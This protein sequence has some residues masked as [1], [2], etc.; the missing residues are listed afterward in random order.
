MKRELSKLEKEAFDN[1]KDFENAIAQQKTSIQKLEKHLKKH[2]RSEDKE[3]KA[4]LERAAKL[5][6]NVQTVIRNNVADINDPLWKRAEELGKKAKLPSNDDLLKNIGDKP[7][8]NIGMSQEAEELSPRSL[9]NSSISLAG[10]LARPISPQMA[11]VIRRLPLSLK[12]ASLVIIQK[13][14][15]KG[16]SPEETLFKLAPNGASIVELEYDLKKPHQALITSGPKLRKIVDLSKDDHIAQAVKA[17]IRKRHEG[18]A[19]R[20]LPQNKKAQKASVLDA[21]ESHKQLQELRATW[22]AL[23]AQSQALAQVREN[24]SKF[25]EGQGQKATFLTPLEGHPVRGLLCAQKYPYVA[26][27]NESG[28]WLKK[29]KV[30]SEL[31]L[32]ALACVESDGR[33]QEGTQLR[34]SGCPIVPKKASSKTPHAQ[35][36]GLAL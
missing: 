9:S 5:F 28:I 19:A 17:V 34:G 33:L 26:L 30:Y 12:K 25:A 20:P 31:P 24:A 14:K 11:E 6:P 21:Q 8:K 27:A 32:G 3:L 36:S 10:D 1:P 23:S 4:L 18:L 13:P 16:S 15:V 7:L 29:L 35:S 2:K 22:R